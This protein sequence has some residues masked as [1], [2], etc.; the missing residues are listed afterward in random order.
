LAPRRP[1]FPFSTSNIALGT[2]PIETA[3]AGLARAIRDAAKR[4]RVDGA[5]FGPF[6]LKGTSDVT[7][8]TFVK[9]SDAWANF[10]NVKASGAFCAL[11]DFTTLH[12]SE[13]GPQSGGLL[14]A[15]APGFESALAHPVGFKN[16]A[17]AKGVGESRL[18]Y[19][20][21]IPP[22]HYV[23]LGIC[24]TDKY[25]NGP[26]KESYWC[27]HEDYVTR[28]GSAAFWSDRGTGFMDDMNLATVVAP[29]VEQVN[30]PNILLVPPTVLSTRAPID[31]YVLRLDKCYL[32]F[33]ESAAE[34]PKPDPKAV[35]GHILSPGLERV[36]VL[37]WVA[38]ANLPGAAAADSP[39][40][41][42]AIKQYWRCIETDN[43]AGDRT[44]T[45][46]SGIEESQ[47]R[48]FRDKTGIELGAEV[49][50]AAGGVS[51]KFT[52]SYSREL[53]VTTNNASTKRYELREERRFTVPDGQTTAFWQRVGGIFIYNSSGDIVASAEMR[54]RTRGNCL[55]ES[56]NG[57]TARLRMTSGRTCAAKERARTG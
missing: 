55:H 10:Y 40:F 46:T 14:L 52:A 54:Y 1:Q 23:P 12:Q 13:C 17:N 18:S 11:G 20:N 15:P 33:P 4:F 42:I 49:G 38:M 9:G 35:T 21:L 48:Q 36:Q 44:I 43:L 26:N 5:R 45:I 6:L 51:A 32:D 41:F 8:L 31:T 39:L 3:D 2:T 50:A 24:F 53:E 22:P 47:S 16:V 27:V 30:P 57:C 37:P 7:C 19:W 34:A 28:T 56:W 25:T 29:S